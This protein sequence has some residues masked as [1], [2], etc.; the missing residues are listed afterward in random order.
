VSDLSQTNVVLIVFAMDGC[1][2]CKEYVPKLQHAIAAYQNAGYPFVIYEI[3][4]KLQPGQIPVLIYDAT[5]QDPGVQALMDQHKVSA[6]P[7]T[8]MLPRS[9]HSGRWEGSMND[10]DIYSI[11]NF[12]IGSNH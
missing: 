5:S 9:G 1:H 11:M 7:T 6:L 2:A 10:A 12:A 8:V 3:G 4:M